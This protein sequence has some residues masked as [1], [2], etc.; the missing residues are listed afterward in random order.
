VAQPGGTTR[1]HRSNVINQQYNL[2][3]C[4]FVNS[5]RLSEVENL[6]RTNPDIKNQ[7]LAQ[8][9]GFGSVDSM[10]RAIFLQTGTKWT[11]WKKQLI[12]K[13]EVD[14]DQ[15]ERTEADYG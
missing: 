2:N 9:C 10:K 14:D 12:E 1:T 5:Y 13:F 15:F 3:F 6:L 8:N 11:E 4:S 7:E